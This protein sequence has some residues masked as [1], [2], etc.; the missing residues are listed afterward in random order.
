M[1][2]PELTPVDLAMHDILRRAITQAVL[3]EAPK[4]HYFAKL[5]EGEKIEVRKR[6]VTLSNLHTA[7]RDGDEHPHELVELSRLRGWFPEYIGQISAPTRSL[8]SYSLLLCQVTS[9]AVRAT[10]TCEHRESGGLVCEAA[11][12]PAWHEHKISEHTQLH[13][14]RGN[15]YSCES[16]DAALIARRDQQSEGAK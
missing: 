8:P 1:S 7:V 14:E 9:R 3:N 6:L 12:D 13:A 16:I 11:G 15:G 2:A 4:N 5:S 10:Y